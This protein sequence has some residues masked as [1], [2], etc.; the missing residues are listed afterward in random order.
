MTSPI[1]S[2]PTH[3]QKKSSVVFPYT[4]H[5]E[6]AREKEIVLSTMAFTKENTQETTYRRT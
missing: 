2:L 4:N 5:I 3:T 6:K 1:N